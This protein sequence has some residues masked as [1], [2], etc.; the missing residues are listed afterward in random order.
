[1]AEL[2]FLKSDNTASSD[3]LNFLKNEKKDNLEF[4]RSDTTE[5]NNLDFLKGTQELEIF[6]VPQSQLE[7]AAPKVQNILTN[8]KDDIVNFYG[9][10]GV[11]EGAKIPGSKEEKEFFSFNTERFPTTEVLGLDIID[12]KKVYNDSENVQDFSSKIGK[13]IA[14]TLVGDVYAVGDAGFKT[15]F[16]PIMGAIS[17]FANTAEEVIL[18]TLGEEGFTELELKLFGSNTMKASEISEGFQEAAHIALADII[19]R[20]P[21][22]TSKTAFDSVANK[23]LNKPLK[24]KIVQEQVKVKAEPYLEA[25][26]ENISDVL[27]KEMSVRT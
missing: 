25:V 18:D 1:M 17:V 5:T 23:V 2:D 12:Y 8:V 7:E 13:N 24:E 4:I 21:R 22:V 26:K 20:A 14:K 11:P 27:A 16:L 9:D 6:G 19:S 15:A 10:V 3:N